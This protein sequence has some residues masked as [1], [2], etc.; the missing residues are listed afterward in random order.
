MREVKCAFIESEEAR[1]NAEI[2]L[3]FIK[4]QKNR[5]KVTFAKKHMSAAS[6]RKKLVA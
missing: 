1:C 2:F 4:L 5:S 6:R 3:K